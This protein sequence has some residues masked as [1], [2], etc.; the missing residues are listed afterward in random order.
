VSQKKAK[1]RRREMREIQS[2]LAEQLRLLAKR[3]KD[4]DEGDWVEAVEIAA[5]L[6]VILNRGSKSKPSVIQN[7][8]A[9]K[10]PLLSTCEHI[11][12]GTLSADSFYRHSFGKDETGVYYQLSP[13]LKTPLYKTYMP[14]PRWWEQI[15][16]ITAS[17]H[18]RHV[19]RRKDVITEVA[20]KGGGTHVASLVPESYDILSQPGGIIKVVLGSETGSEEVPIAGVPFV[21]LQQMGYEILNNPALLDL[22]DPEKR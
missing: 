11:P 4:F 3:C 18:E 15:V 20:N 2:D 6:R 19:F 22:C 14:A 1:Q 9:E 17:Q 5:R 21:M 7:L 12:E 8:G 13:K 16:D 10:V